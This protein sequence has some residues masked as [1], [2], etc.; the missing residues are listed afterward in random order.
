MQSHFYISQSKIGQRGSLLLSRQQG[1]TSFRKNR[2]ISRAMMTVALLLLVFQIVPVSA[3]SVANTIVV[4]TLDDVVDGGDGVTSL[5]EAINTAVN[6]DTI[7][8]DASLSGGT[9]TLNGTHLLI[10]NKS[11]TIESSVPIAIS[12]NNQSRVFLIV[13]YSNITLD[14]LTIRDGYMATPDPCP[15]AGAFCGGGI[16]ANRSNVTVLNSQVVDN[17]ADQ[18]AGIYIYNDGT[19]TV[20]NSTF[21]DNNATVAGGALRGEDANGIHVSNSLLYNN[22][23]PAGGVV[24]VYSTPLSF[25]NSTLSQNSAPY[26]GGAIQSYT[27]VT[28]VTH[29]T[30]TG[31]SSPTGAVNQDVGGS[32]TIYGS[33]IANNTG[34]DCA[35][36]IISNGYNIDSDG[37]C[38]DGTVTTDQPTVDPLLDALADN[39]GPTMTQALLTGSPAIDVI[40]PGA[41]SCVAGVSTDQRGA[42]RA[43]GTDRGDSGCDVGAF[44]YGSNQNPTAVTMQSFTAGIGEGVGLATAVAAI[45]LGTLSLA[46]MVLWLQRRR[47]Q[48]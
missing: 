28:T 35:G 37:T 41:G 36:T 5:R 10:V 12:G 42:V 20:E 48:S 14:G 11:I 18:G 26:T 13:S 30:I 2:I 44:E 43:D 47:V 23:A 3:D 34:N 21:S 1:A 45:L 8:F 33:I 9:I 19:L 22:S 27:S 24:D 25:T 15:A 32:V 46:V 39:G 17:T 29:S 38:F 6:G 16:Y 40:A 31:N 7:T 4:D